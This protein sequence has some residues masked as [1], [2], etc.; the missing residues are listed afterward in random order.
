ML[1]GVVNA[2]SAPNFAANLRTEQVRQRFAP[3]DIQVVHHQMDRFGL[4]I[5]AEANSKTDMRKTRR[6]DRSGWG[7]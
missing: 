2:E 4:G 3:M 5:L 6:A 7:M 1:G